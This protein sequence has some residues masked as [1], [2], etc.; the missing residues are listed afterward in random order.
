MIKNFIVNGCSFSDDSRLNTN[1]V[2]WATYVNKNLQFDYYQNL[3]RAGAGN[4]YICESTIGFLET[5]NLDPDETCVI[6]M[7]SGTGRKDLRISG[8]WYFYLKNKYPFLSQAGYNDVDY[9]LFSGGLTNSWMDIGEVKKIFDWL[10]KLSDPHS[11]CLDSLTNMIKLESYLQNQGYSY[12]M[13]SFQ[14]LWQGESTVTGDY[15]IPWFL[16][17]QVILKNYEFD[18]WFFINQKKDCL[19]EFS[20][21]LKEIDNTGHPTA[22]AHE[23]FANQIVIPELSKRFMCKVTKAA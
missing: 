1:T 4:S 17:D 14:N 10:Y 22:L 2:T 16:K 21:N 19:G 20:R 8:D 18:H 13:T 15:C 5:Q 23:M 7:W 9:Y 6:I 3:A 12:A 11:L